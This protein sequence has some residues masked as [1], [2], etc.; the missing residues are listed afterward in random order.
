[1]CIDFDTT[2]VKKGFSLALVD[3]GDAL[4]FYGT[5]INAKAEKLERAVAAKD[6]FPTLAYIADFPLTGECTGAIL[7]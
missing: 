3:L 1:M 7:Y 6:I 2:I 5:G 4:A